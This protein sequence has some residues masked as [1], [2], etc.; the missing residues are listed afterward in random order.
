MSGDAGARD[1]KQRG[2]LTCGRLAVAQRVEDR[3]STLVG[4]S[5]QYGIHEP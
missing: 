3:A 4:E 1:V 5:V 2:Q